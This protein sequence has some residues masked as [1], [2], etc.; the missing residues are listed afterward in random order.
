ME[1]QYYVRVVYMSVCTSVRLFVPSHVIGRA[2]LRSKLVTRD[3]T[4]PKFDT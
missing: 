2:I 3:E 4:M 1:S